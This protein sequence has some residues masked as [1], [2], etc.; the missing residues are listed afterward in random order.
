M[1]IQVLPKSDTQHP[2]SIVDHAINAIQASG[3][4]YQVCPF[5]TVVEGSLEQVMNLAHKIHETCYKNGAS[6]M[7]TY[8]KIQSKKDE[9][10]LIDDKMLKYKHL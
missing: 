5:E 6:E 2:Y 1:A 8:I 4:N 7:M 9:D 10:V 3:L